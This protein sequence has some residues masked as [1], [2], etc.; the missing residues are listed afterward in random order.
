VEAKAKCL[1]TRW[2]NAGAEAKQLVNLY[3]SGEATVGD[4]KRLASY[5]L[6]GTLLFFAGEIVGRGSFVGYKESRD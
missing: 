4:V 1:T 6:G 5:V 2:G 3:R